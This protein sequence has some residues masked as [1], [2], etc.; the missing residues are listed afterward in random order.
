M[1][2]AKSKYPS[3]GSYPFLR[4]AR[5]SQAFLYH[6]FD[7]DASGTSMAVFSRAQAAM[8]QS[9]SL[10]FCS[11]SYDPLAPRLL[12]LSADFCAGNRSIARF[13]L[14]DCKG[15]VR[16]LLLAKSDCGQAPFPNTGLVFHIVHLSCILLD[17]MLDA[18]TMLFLYSIFST[19]DLLC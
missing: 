9:S 1:V 19:E 7:K 15:L 8:A 17:F 12:L 3:S 16:L 10:S 14:R 18:A 5:R 13:V 4:V 11:L 2:L 6:A